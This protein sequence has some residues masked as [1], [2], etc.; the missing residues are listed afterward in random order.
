M[1]FRSHYTM[2]WDIL[3]RIGMKYQVEYVPEYMG[4]LREYPEAKSFA[5]GVARVRE[6]RRMLQRHTGLR[7]SPGGRKILRDQGAGQASEKSARSIG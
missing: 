1:L 6:I 7:V 4:C 5:G 3:I 2:D